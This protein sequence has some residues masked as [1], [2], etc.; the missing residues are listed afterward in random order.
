MPETHFYKTQFLSV[1]EHSPLICGKPNHYSI[2]PVRPSSEK[3]SLS[4]QDTF[5]VQ[6]SLFPLQSYTVINIKGDRGC[7]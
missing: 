6:V 2:D 4:H 5:T 7:S 3:T 1:A